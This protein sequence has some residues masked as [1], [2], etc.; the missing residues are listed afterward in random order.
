MN[1]MSH[2]NPPS[3]YDQV[4]RTSID[5][6]VFPEKGNTYI[7]QSFWMRWEEKKLSLECLKKKKIMDAKSV[8]A[9]L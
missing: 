7:F 2:Q 1:H 5:M 8:C 4:L 3:F 6:Y 9:P